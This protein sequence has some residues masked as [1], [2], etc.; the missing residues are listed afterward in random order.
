MKFKAF[1]ILFWAAML[2]TVPYSFAQGLVPKSK[3]TD[4]V[5]GLTEIESFQGTLNSGERLFKL[6]STLGWDFNKHFGIFGGVPVYLVNV[7]STTTATGTT[8]TTTPSSSNNGI[9]NAYFGLAFRAPNP[10]IDYSSTFTAGAP[11]GNSKKGLSSGRGTIDWDNRLEHAFD[12][13]TPFLD[14]GIGNTV[15]DSALF[16]RP[17]TSLGFVAH[18]QEGAEFD[19]LK[20]VG[21]GALVY[22]VVPAGNQKVF[23][24]LVKKGGTA[25]GSGKSSR[26]FETAAE[27]SGNGLTRENGFS[28]WIGFEPSPV[29]RLELGYTRSVSFDLSSFAFNLSVNVGKLLRSKKKS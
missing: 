27:T 2:T 10:A 17:F 13:L 25:I 8:T 28:T 6:D 26:V 22:E 14:V 15:P 24:R 7:P 4:D 9:G 12:R 21:V 23:S 16:T 19:L 1:K 29:W 11:T 20:H 3:E 5:A 18:L